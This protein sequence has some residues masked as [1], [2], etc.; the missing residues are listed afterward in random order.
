VSSTAST[1]AQASGLEGLKSSLLFYS[2]SGPRAQPWAPNSTSFLCIN[3]PTQRTSARSTGGSSSS[4]N[5]TF[6]LDLLA[7]TSANAG[8]LGAPF[9]PGNVLAAQ[10]WYRDPPAPRG[11]NLS[12]AIQFTLAP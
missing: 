12:A 10:V 9:A 2:L 5:G 7:W 8:S 11:T 3:G 6:A 1:T 4:C